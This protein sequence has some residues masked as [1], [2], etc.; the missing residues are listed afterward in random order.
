MKSQACMLM[1]APD[2]TDLRIH[3]E[4]R[5]SSD[6]LPLDPTRP[7][8][9]MGGTEKLVLRLAYA[10]ASR[11]HGVT[12]RGG[13]ARC[14]HGGVRLFADGE[15][16]PR[17]DVLVSVHADAP[18]D[19]DATLRIAWSHAAQ[20]PARAAD[21]DLAVVGS[22]YHA[23][24][25][26]GRLSDLPV[27]VL[28]PGVDVVPD[29]G[30][31]RDRFLYAS[32]PDRGLHRLLAMWPAIWS[33]FGLP[34][35]IGYDVRA[36]LARR[37]RSTSALGDRL[38]DLAARL[39]QPG[40]IVHGAL[41]DAQLEAL[42]QRSLALLYPLDPVLPHSELL[43]LTV[44]EACAAGCPPI[45]SPVDAF[46]SEYAD[47]A[48]FMG[49]DGPSFDPQ[50]WVHAIQQTLDDWRG[51]SELARRYAAGRSWDTWVSG[52]ER[53]L[54]T[55][56][57]ARALPRGA[58]QTWL[59]VA[60]GAGELGP[61]HFL[62]EAASEAGHDVRVLTD[63][64]TLAPAGC[65][66]ECVASLSPVLDAIAGRPDRVVL[67]SDPQPAAL[68]RMVAMMGIPL[69]TVDSG[70]RPWMKESP[71]PGLIPL[72]C[73]PSSLVELAV[74]GEA[75]LFPVDNGLKHR[76]RGVG[77]LPLAAGR[78]GRVGPRRALIWLNT[79]G[80][81]FPDALPAALD[82]LRSSVGLQANCITGGEAIM[83]PSWVERLAETAP[84][85]TRAL[86]AGADLLICTPDPS[87]IGLARA[88]GTAVLVLA[89]G[90]C[91]ST[92]PACEQD[93]FAQV[94]SLGDEAQVVWD[95]M[96]TSTLTRALTM[97]LAGTATPSGD[98]ARRAVR[99]IEAVAERL[100]EPRARP[101]ELV[102]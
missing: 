61:A 73:W 48:R 87:L 67:C 19:V 27:H 20:W 38:R 58:R 92:D 84:A 90:L 94:L 78:A 66:S 8:R 89:P 47:V 30:A 36:V 86:I 52:W 91:F 6:W 35:S 9:M 33:R 64:A 76:V 11:G 42:R 41:A 99:L 12:V 44:L 83:L 32:S 7:D 15:A 82:A 1:L 26:R 68:F 3:L 31:R 95:Q 40:V 96:P 18:G 4:L 10:L 24:L 93:R 45:L 23:D 63:S 37:G 80:E 5:L 56:P 43:S 70:V 22:E 55:G 21:W 29:S 13:G 28:S 74:S 97:A 100:I 75:P 71:P 50:E 46:P 65:R 57:R 79:Q 62:A 53:L 51:R 69:V 25:I 81:W 85:S 17:T 77:W 34:L 102:P 88:M 60:L 98:G 101:P 16:V 54:G 2:T 49:T 39:D 72:V 59:I 14:E